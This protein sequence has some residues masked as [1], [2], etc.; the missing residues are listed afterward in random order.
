L[1]PYNR[2]QV[3]KG[4]TSTWKDVGTTSQTVAFSNGESPYVSEYV[5]AGKIW[6]RMVAGDGGGA[7]TCS[8]LILDQIKLTL[9]KPD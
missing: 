3:F 2:L 5:Y 8:S 7:G 9:N 6:F 1:T 4:N